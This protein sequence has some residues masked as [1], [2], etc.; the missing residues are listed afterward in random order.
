MPDSSK[1]TEPESFEKIIIVDNVIT[2]KRNV[3]ESQL[4]KFLKVPSLT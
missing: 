2:G 1:G 4:T 3:L